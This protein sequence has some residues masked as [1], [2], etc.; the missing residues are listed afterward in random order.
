[1][2]HVCNSHYLSRFAAFFIDVRTK[3]SVVESFKF[4]KFSDKLVKVLKL[5]RA[6]SAQVVPDRA[7]AEAFGAGLAFHNVGV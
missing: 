5:G 1:M 4:F 2:T 6:S 3:R 7:A